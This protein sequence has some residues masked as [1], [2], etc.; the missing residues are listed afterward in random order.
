MWRAAWRPAAGVPA[1]TEI[2]TAKF[3]TADARHR[4]AHTA[5]PVHADVGI[6]LDYPLHRYFT[7]AK[8]CEF[9]LGGATAQLRHIG[10]ALASAG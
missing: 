10:T 8:R 6:D 4:V 3:W 1:D 9:A 2:A 7:A 5:V